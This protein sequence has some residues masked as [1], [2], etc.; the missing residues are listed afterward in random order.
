VDS[1]S[2]TFDFSFR[3]D[4]ILGDIDDDTVIN[5]GSSLGP[6]V[7]LTISGFGTF[8][9]GGVVEAVPEPSTWAL[10]LLGF[11]GLGFVGYRTNSRWPTTNC[12]P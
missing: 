7:D 2:S 6:D 9:I 10:M 5:L 1:A 12:R 11:A 3:G 4:L 8:V